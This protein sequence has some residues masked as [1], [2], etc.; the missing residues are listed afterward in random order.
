MGRY[1][2]ADTVLRDRRQKTSQNKVLYIYIVLSVCDLSVTWLSTSHLLSLFW[3]WRT[4]I[5]RDKARN[6]V[7][8]VC[9]Y[10]RKFMSTVALR[11]LYITTKEW[12]ELS[13]TAH[14][15]YV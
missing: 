2:T 10:N 8:A 1:L 6:T 12:T 13:V 4:R 11:L 7:V 14:T 15:Q 9:N 5:V 3:Y